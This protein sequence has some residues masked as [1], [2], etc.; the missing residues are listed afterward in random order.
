[1][2]KLNLD[3]NATPNHILVTSN[4]EVAY[5]LPLWCKIDG[6]SSYSTSN[7]INWKIDTLNLSVEDTIKHIK[8]TASELMQFFYGRHNIEFSV[9]INKDNIS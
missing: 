4:H 2:E 6:H 5:K 7:N 9:E 1:M 8:G 3:I